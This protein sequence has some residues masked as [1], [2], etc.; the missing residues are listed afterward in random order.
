MKTFKNIYVVKINV[1]LVDDDTEM[2]HALKEGFKKYQESFAIL[3]A[4]DGLQALKSLKQN[5]ISLVVTDLKMSNVGGMEV[6][7][8]LKASYPETMVIVITGYSTVS[9]AVE[10]WS[11]RMAD[12]ASAA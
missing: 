3:L 1:L 6:L 7:R 2:L 4:E 10:A 5:I 9:S 11:A 8:R 12:T